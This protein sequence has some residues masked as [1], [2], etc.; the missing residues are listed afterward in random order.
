MQ[1]GRYAWFGGRNDRGV[2]VRQID[3]EMRRG[4]G[5]RDARDAT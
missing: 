4:T 3:Q 5:V 2:T 1:V